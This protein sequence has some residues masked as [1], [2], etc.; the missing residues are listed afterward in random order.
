LTVPRNRSCSPKHRGARSVSVTDTVSSRFTTELYRG[1]ARA[2]ARSRLWAKNGVYGK[3]DCRGQL[4]RAAV[5]HF[6]GITTIAS[7]HGQTIRIARLPFRFP[8]AAVP[9]SDRYPP[10]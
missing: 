2:G 7:A 8:M 5:Q 6:T 3:V 10:G 1:R 9:A 4:R